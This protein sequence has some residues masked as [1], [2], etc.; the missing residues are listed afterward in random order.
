MYIYIYIHI[1][2]MHRYMCLYIYIYIYTY[3]YM[4]IYIY[5]RERERERETEREREQL[6]SDLRPCESV[7]VPSRSTS[8]GSRSIKVS[9]GKGP[10]A[11][12]SRAPPDATPRLLRILPTSAQPC[13]A[14]SSSHSMSPGARGAPP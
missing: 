3:I 7:Q 13:R 9:L 4:Y 5:T 11:N 10:L 8:S 2:H 1:F 14:R 12:R 6:L